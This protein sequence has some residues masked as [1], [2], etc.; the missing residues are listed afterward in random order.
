MTVKNSSQTTY[1]NRIKML[2]RLYDKTFK[3]NISINEMVKDINRTISI[4]EDHY[5]NDNKKH[6]T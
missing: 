3:T 5:K 1:N 4:V 6:G 2:K